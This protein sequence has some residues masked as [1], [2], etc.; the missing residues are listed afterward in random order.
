MGT[1]FNA[2]A[3]LGAWALAGP[4]WGAM[5]FVVIALVRMAMDA[6]ALREEN[7]ELRRLLWDARRFALDGTDDAD[8]IDVPPESEIRASRPNLGR[9]R[10]SE[11]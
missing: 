7:H 11:V 4:F 5:I 8:A 2:S 6:H 3:A 10:V 1:L 9:A